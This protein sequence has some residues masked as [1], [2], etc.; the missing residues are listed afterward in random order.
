[1]SGLKCPDQ[2]NTF[3]VMQFS[4]RRGGRDKRY[5]RWT[6]DADLL[7]LDRHKEAA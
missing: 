6:T 7:M 2:A 3:H 4:G 5:A 1:V